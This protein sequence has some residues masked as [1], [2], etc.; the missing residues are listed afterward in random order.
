M[1]NLVRAPLLNEVRH[2]TTC[3]HRIVMTLCGLLRSKTAKS[4]GRVSWLCQ[5]VESRGIDALL[6]YQRTLSPSSTDYAMAGVPPQRRGS[7]QPTMPATGNAP[8]TQ[9]SVP[10]R[11]RADRLV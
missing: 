9:A 10:L 5:L 2:C 8:N 3:P 4:R 7:G 11:V 6:W 1:I